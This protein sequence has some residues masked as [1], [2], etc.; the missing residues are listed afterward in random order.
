MNYTKIFIVLLTLIQKP[1]MVACWLWCNEFFCLSRHDLAC[2]FSFLE[3]LMP[4][5]SVNANMQSW[6][7]CVCIC[8]YLKIWSSKKSPEVLPLWILPSYWHDTVVFDKTRVSK[9]QNIKF[10]VSPSSFPVCRM[11]N[12]W[13]VAWAILR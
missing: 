9:Y 4:F 3:C 5:P 11:E 2:L 1:F 6:R 7:K 8:D 12:W 10:V 13:L